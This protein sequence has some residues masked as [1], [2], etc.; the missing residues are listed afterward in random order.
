MSIAG[1]MTQWNRMM[2]LPT[3]WNWAG[4]RFSNSSALSGLP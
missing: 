1:Q 2:S 4:Q 3:K